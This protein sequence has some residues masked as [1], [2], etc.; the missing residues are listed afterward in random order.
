MA[1]F[2][3]VH[4]EKSG[5]ACAPTFLYNKSAGSACYT[6]IHLPMARGSLVK[7]LSMSSGDFAQG[8]ERP[9][10]SVRGAAS[11]TP[12]VSLSFQCVVRSI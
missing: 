7:L 3:D 4:F 10:R 12:I 8:A 9:L 2:S 11:V 5:L 1:S 6:H